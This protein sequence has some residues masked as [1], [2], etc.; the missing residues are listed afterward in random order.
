MDSTEKIPGMFGT[1]VI[2]LPSPHQGGNLVAKHCGTSKTFKT[3]NSAQ[4]YLV[5]LRCAP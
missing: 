1:L 2:C 3:D 4:S 5:V